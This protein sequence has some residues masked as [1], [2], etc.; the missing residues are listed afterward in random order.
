MRAAL[1]RF[2]KRGKGK[3]VYLVGT[4]VCPKNN[5][6]CEKDLTFLSVTNIITDRNLICRMSKSNLILLRYRKEIVYGVFY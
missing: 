1:K 4:C 2:I 6:F 5:L 3:S